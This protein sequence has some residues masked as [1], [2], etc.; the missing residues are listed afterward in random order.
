MANDCWKIEKLCGSAQDVR[1]YQLCIGMAVSING[2]V[3]PSTR[4][5]CIN[6]PYALFLD[7]FIQTT[8]GDDHAEEGDACLDIP[9]D[10]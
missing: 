5:G 1:V 8:I 3:C 6:W 9:P 2:A 10:R 7:P 4:L